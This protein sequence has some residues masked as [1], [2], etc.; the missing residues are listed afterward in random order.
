MKNLTYFKSLADE[1]RIRL[2]HVLRYN[3]LTVNEIVALLQMGQSRVSHHLKILNEAGFL[4]C[5]RDGIWAFYSLRKNGT[6]HRMIQALRFLFDDDP[7]LLDICRGCRIGFHVCRP[8]LGFG[9]GGSKHFSRAVKTRSPA[10]TLP[11]QYLTKSVLFYPS[12]PPSSWPKYSGGQSPP[13][14]WPSLRH[15]DL[16]FHHRFR[17]AQDKPDHHQN[18][19]NQHDKPHGL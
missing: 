10:K 17:R 6:G 12:Q 11:K 9:W 13:A 16:V 1:T 19:N 18:E 8:I 14:P 3:E 7:L 4:S 2:V 15:A 5:R